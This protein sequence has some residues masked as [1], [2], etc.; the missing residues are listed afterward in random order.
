[1]DLL[2]IEFAERCERIRQAVE[3]RFAGSFLGR[4]LRRSLAGGTEVTEH[5]DY[6]TGD[7]YRY[8]DWNRAARLDELV[9]RQFHGS[10]C[11]DVYLLIDNSGSMQLPRSPAVS[12]FDRARQLAALLGYLAIRRQDTVV[13]ATL[14]GPPLPASERITTSHGFQ[15]L[16]H[17]LNALQISP[18]TPNLVDAVQAFLRSDQR[19]GSV[20]L[21]SDLLD[22]QGFTRPLDALRRYGHDVFVVQFF[23]PCDAEPEAAGNVA[24]QDIESSELQQS[25]VDAEDLQHYSEEFADYCQ[26]ISTY[27]CQYGLGLTRVSTR[28]SPEQALHR[29]LRCGEA[30]AAARSSHAAPS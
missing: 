18:S 3:G 6:T 26:E 9:T 14:D 15:P 8:V 27:C 5:S 23:A 21:L 29:I 4:P 11:E 20:V 12:K 17:F 24:L 28:D 16:W 10:T 2:D 22:R 13:A 25:F 7:D 1:M 30:R 19:P